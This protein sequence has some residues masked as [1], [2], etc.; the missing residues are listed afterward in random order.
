[1]GI[2]HIVRSVIVDRLPNRYKNEI[3]RRYFYSCKGDYI[4]PEVNI[5]KRLCNPEKVSLDIGANRGTFT[6]YLSKLSRYVYSFEPLPQ[7]SNYLKRN[8]EGC[9]VKVENCALG[10]EKKEVYINVPIVGLKEYDAYSSL[11][12]DFRNEYILREK[13]TKVDKLIVRQERLDDFNIDNIGFIKI[14]VEGYEV[15]VLE[16]AK[17]TIRLNMPFMFIEIEQ[18]HNK[19]RSI[20]DI[21]KYIKDLGYYGYFVEN[22]RFINI[23][24]FDINKYQDKRNEGKRN[25][26]INDFVFSPTPIVD[27]KL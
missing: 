8:F 27:D 15:E 22:K 16:G 25:L 26:Y 17:K 24:T 20:Y 4:K 5:L 12:N 14:D 10:N 11:V 23:D 2:K 13:V 21:F 18:K 19:G 1:M 7:L 6:L 3:K 9:N